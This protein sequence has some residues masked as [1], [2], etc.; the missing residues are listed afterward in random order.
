V[1]VAHENPSD[2]EEALNLLQVNSSHHIFNAIATVDYVTVIDS[3]ASMSGTGD[4]AMLKNLCPITLTVSSAFGESAQPT[5]MGDLQPHMIP[6]VLIDDMKNA[7]LLSVC[8]MCGQKIPLCGILSP[9][10]CR[11]F[12]FHQMLPYLKLVNEVCD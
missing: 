3:G 6:T 12:L 4:R 5:E 10:D 7:T 2:N 1:R 11:F 8:Q 9:V